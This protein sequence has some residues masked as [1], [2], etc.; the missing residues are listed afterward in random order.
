MGIQNAHLSHSLISLRVYQMLEDVRGEEHTAR[1]KPCLQALGE[2]WPVGEK[3]EIP[4]CHFYCV[5]IYV[6][7]GTV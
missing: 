4:T 3:H 2:L 6:L 1:N 7:D 5:Y